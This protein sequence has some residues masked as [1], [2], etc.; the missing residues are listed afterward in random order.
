MVTLSAYSNPVEAAIAKSRLDDHKIFCA[1]ADENMNLYGGGP[2]AMPIRLLVA[3]D[4]AEEA[5]RI[6][7]L[8]IRDLRIASSLNL[9]TRITLLRDL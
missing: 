1:L 8:V 9:S 3:E 4:Q 7:K 5:A 2:M 6:W